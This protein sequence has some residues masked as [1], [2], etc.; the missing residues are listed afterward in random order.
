MN[1]PTKKNCQETLDK[2]REITK[3]PRL[4]ET[5][6][7]PLIDELVREYYGETEDTDSNDRESDK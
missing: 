4:Y 5:E 1:N 6:S 2:I 7:F 3:N